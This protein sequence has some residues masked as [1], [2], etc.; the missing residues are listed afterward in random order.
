MT[1]RSFIIIGS[2]ILF[3]AWPCAGQEGGSGDTPGVRAAIE[4]AA[5]QYEAAFAKG[6]AKAVAAMFAE[7]VEY[8]DEDGVTVV[9]R[10]AVE[11]VLRQSFAR[12]KGAK[13]AIGIDSVR[14]LGPDVAVERGTTLMTGADGVQISS[15][16]TAVR[17]RKNDK[18]LIGQIVESPPPAPAPGEMLSELAWL[19]GTW[20]EKDGDTEVETKVDWSKGGNFLTR[21]FKVTLAGD[22]TMEGWQIIAWDAAREQIRSWLFD[23]GG[24]FSEGIWTSDGTG[25]LIRQAGTL[26]DGGRTSA[27]S[28][29]R[30]AG[31]DKFI[32]ESTNRTLDGEPQPNLPKIEATRIK[33]K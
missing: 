28:T 4:Q 13:L 5:K 22:V 8:T 33:E 17:V 1:K 24:A 16:Y 29:L 12:N 2:S 7:D 3:A 18:W 9:G 26:P 31:D 21:T 27:D 19:V 15:A 20:K 11:G 6:D 14:G 32:W 30:R 25:W 10:E 23:S